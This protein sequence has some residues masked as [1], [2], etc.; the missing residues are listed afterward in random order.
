MVI[1]VICIVTV[2][3]CVFVVPA[4]NKYFDKQEK[5]AK[6]AEKDFQKKYGAELQKLDCE[7]CNL[8]SDFCSEED[9]LYRENIEIN[10]RT[11]QSK[12]KLSKSSEGELVW[13][14][15]RTPEKYQIIDKNHFEIIP[16]K[17]GYLRVKEHYPIDKI[18]FF[19]ESGTLQYTTS[20]QG[21]GVNVAGAVVGGM[22]AGTAGALIG[23]RQEVKSTTIEHDDRK[24]VLKLNDGTEK[25]YDYK[26][27]NY[28]IKLIPEKEYSFVMAKS[29]GI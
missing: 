16:N 18:M 8:C 1:I 19:R 24:V 15:Y 10:N 6:E 2:I 14:E 25:V 20:V 3:F 17:A 4:L 11:A 13:Y 28:F 7:Y 5:N 27:Y 23:S 12:F 22:V 21:G 26:Y 29:Q 9:R